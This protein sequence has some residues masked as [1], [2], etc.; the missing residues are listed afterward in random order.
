VEILPC[1]QHRVIEITRFLRDR[2]PHDAALAAGP[3]GSWPYIF[4]P[5]SHMG[6][7]SST[8]QGISI[9]QSRMTYRME[10]APVQ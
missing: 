5:R 10:S 9:V 2:G 8:V 1:G 6:E 4:W 7:S 3:G